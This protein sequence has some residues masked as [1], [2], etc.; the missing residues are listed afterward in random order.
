MH[1]VTI[2][3]SLSILRFMGLSWAFGKTGVIIP[4]LQIGKQKPGK[5]KIQFRGSYWPTRDSQASWHS[6]P[7]GPKESLAAIL[8]TTTTMYLRL[9]SKGVVFWNYKRYK[10]KISATLQLQQTWL[11]TTQLLLLVAVL[12]TWS[13]LIR[14]DY[15]KHLTDVEYLR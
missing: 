13:C 9:E 6:V 11:L 12:S 5:T 2:L 7:S 10:I 15:F 4:V 3:I 1:T 8:S 14:K